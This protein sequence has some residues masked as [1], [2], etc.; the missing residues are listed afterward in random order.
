MSKIGRETGVLLIHGKKDRLIDYSHSVELHS[1][2]A[3]GVVSE[4]VLPENMT[5]NHFDFFSDFI[6]PIFKFF[7]KLKYETHPSR[8]IP[9]MTLHPVF[10]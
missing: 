9:F 1:L 5:H 6:G 7:L 4:L 10:K 3:P 2:L 8:R